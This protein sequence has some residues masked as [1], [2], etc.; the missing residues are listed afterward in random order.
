LCAHMK[1]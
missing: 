1:R